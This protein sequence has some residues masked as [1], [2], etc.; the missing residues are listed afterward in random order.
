MSPPDNLDKEPTF[1]LS[2]LTLIGC[3]APELTYIAGRCGYNAISPRFIPM[4][5]DGEFPC[6]P[7]DEDIVHATKTAL[8]VTGLQVNEL[9][10]I[11]IHDNLVVKDVERA[12]ALGGDLDARHMITSAWTSRA[13]GKNFI[14]DRYCELCETAA[15]YDMSV[16]LEFPTFSSLKTLKDTSEIVQTANQK[17]GGILIDTI[18]TYFSQLDLNEIDDLPEKW[19]RFVHIADAP[20]KRPKTRADQIEI[21]R[22]GRLYL[23]EGAINFQDIMAHLPAMTYSI[24]IPNV[25]RVAELGYEE[26]ARRCLKAAKKTLLNTK[27][28]D[29]AHNPVG[30]D[31]KFYP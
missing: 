22:A 8:D 4:H 21:A 3:S 26:H 5:I 13:T 18:Y 19:F 30:E 17:N 2:H 7:E 16:D 25:M 12:I 15:Q 10:L 14:I 9:E 28:H 6:Y 29:L 11:K 1:S 27:Q 23:G 31:A 20:D 24:E